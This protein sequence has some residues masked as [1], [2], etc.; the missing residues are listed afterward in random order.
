MTWYKANRLGRGNYTR[1]TAVR[2]G[3]Q[4]RKTRFTTRR[5]RKF[6][7]V[8]TC[9]RWRLHA[10]STV[11]GGIAIDYDHPTSYT[12]LREAQESAD[13]A[14]LAGFHWH[15]GEWRIEGTSTDFPDGITRPRDYT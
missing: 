11:V 5:D 13:R 2:F 9:W 14:A 4:E 6:A 15:D 1:F 12:T 10:Y 3:D 7:S 8:G